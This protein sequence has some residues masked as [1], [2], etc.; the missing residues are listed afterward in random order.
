MSPQESSSRR[1]ILRMSCKTPP[2]LQELAEDSLLKNQALAVAAL[3]DL[4]SLF[5][6]SLFKKA[7]RHRLVG[8]IKAM[9]QAWPFPCLPL[10]AMVSRKTAYRRI[11]EIVLYGFDALL[12]QEVPHR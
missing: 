2:V 7:C 6:P 3:D 8:I 10:G 4:P 9:V 11:L 5:F 1:S 12:F